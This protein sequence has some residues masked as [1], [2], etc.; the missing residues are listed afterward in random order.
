MLA[1]FLDLPKSQTSSV[2]NDLA[3]GGMTLYRKGDHGTE[4]IES[5]FPVVTTMTV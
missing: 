2:S 4:V 3:V 5:D 1:E